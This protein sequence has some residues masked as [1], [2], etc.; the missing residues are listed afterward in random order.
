MTAQDVTG[1]FVKGEQRTSRSSHYFHVFNP[2]TGDVIARVPDCTED[3]VR[4]LFAYKCSAAG[5]IS[6]VMQRVQIIFTSSAN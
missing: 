6:Q 4:P 1:Y 3:E 5:P 2:S